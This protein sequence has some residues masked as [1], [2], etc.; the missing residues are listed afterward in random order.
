MKK[1][2]L[3]MSLL[4]FQTTYSLSENT[5][6]CSNSPTELNE[7]FSTIINVLNKA[8]ASN[9]Q[10]S[11]WVKWLL[12]KTLDNWLWSASV[13]LFFSLDSISDFFANF[14]VIFHQSYI[15]RD[16]GKL[17]NF[18]PYLTN[19][20]LQLGKNWWLYQA[21]PENLK[22]DITQK[23]NKNPYFLLQ[24]AW[25]NYAN[26][27]KFLRK[28]QLAIEQ[29]YFKT[30]VT[31]DIGSCKNIDTTFIKHIEPLLWDFPINKNH[32]INLCENFKQ[33]YLQPNWDEIVCDK[34][35]KKIW[36]EWWAKLKQIWIMSEDTSDRYKC[37]WQRLLNAIFGSPID[38]EC[39]WYGN[40]KLVKWW[41]IWIKW[42]ISIEWAGDIVFNMVTNSNKKIVDT[43]NF[44]P[45]FKLLKEIWNN[46]SWYFHSTKKL[47][48]EIKKYPTTSK[49]LSPDKQDFIETINIISE[50]VSNYKKNMSVR[51]WWTYP[52]KIWKWI[53]PKFPELSY[54]IRKWICTISNNYPGCKEWSKNLNWLKLNT[55]PWIYE[56]LVQTCENES[57]QK[58]NCKYPLQK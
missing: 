28:N 50:K 24:F 44:N 39:K 41:H 23:S 3:I 48:S 47:F 32:V 35:L 7:Y 16:W 55:D 40:V 52:G 58:W 19:K 31:K 6:I 56:N 25:T 22:N 36:T 51:I 21:L 5:E 2:L 10:N 12:D 53:W 13:L 4:I 11:W 1:I 8:Q 9:P 42:K 30:V 33:N 15:V 57:P 49:N 18:K 37:N 34:D 26:L 46:L 29:L 17:K 54:Y 43:S 20:F 14:I 27:I 38:S 45:D